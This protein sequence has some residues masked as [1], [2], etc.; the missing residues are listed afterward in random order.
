VQYHHS[1][2]TDAA[3]VHVFAH[4]PVAGDRTGESG[5]DRGFKYV[6]RTS[7]DAKMYRNLKLRALQI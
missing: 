4:Q 5:P 1:Q 3:G 7:P 6:F 2:V